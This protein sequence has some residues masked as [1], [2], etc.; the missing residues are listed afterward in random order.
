[1]IAN[2]DSDEQRMRPQVCELE[3]DLQVVGLSVALGRSSTRESL[4]KLCKSAFTRNAK[5]KF[6]IFTSG[7]LG[8][9]LKIQQAFKSN[10]V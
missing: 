4:F 9:S 5:R 8:H 3:L 1:M 10:F 7:H 6:E 2:N